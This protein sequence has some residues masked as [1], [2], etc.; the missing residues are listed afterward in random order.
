MSSEERVSGEG[1]E[2]LDNPGNETS[3]KV[4]FEIKSIPKLSLFQT[5]SIVISSVGGVGIFVAMS[6]MMKTTGSVGVL[7]IIVLVSGLL[8]YSLA[9]CF[10]E[11]ATILPKAGGPYFFILDVFGEFPAFLFIWG[12]VFL[13]IAPAWAYLAYAS[14]LYMVQL[15][16]P[17]CRPP[18]EA[19]KLLAACIL[20]KILSSF[21]LT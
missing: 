11:V 1:L 2:L 13:I 20:G 4:E 10:A 18:D 19:V 6:T 16:F 14:S 17:G 3:P 9:K 15:F 21:K 8:N 5:C 7:L 12:F